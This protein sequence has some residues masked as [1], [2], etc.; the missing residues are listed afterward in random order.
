MIQEL[1]DANFSLEHLFVTKENL[2]D[3]KYNFE[4]I[5][6]NDLKKNIGVNYSE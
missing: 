6:D 5:S 1:I 4:L 3:S 2:F